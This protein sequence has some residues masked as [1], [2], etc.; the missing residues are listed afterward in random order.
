MDIPAELP[1]LVAVK[2]LSSQS[3]YRHLHGSLSRWLKKK[4]RVSYIIFG[5]GVMTPH[6][7]GMSA[8]DSV[9][10]ETLGEMRITAK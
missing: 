5:G 8:F 1:T 9:R 4:K 2:S 10:L 7:E 3:L 6:V